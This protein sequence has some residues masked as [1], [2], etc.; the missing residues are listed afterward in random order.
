MKILTTLKHYLLEV[1]VAVVGYVKARLLEKSTWLGISA[2]VTAAAALTPPYSYMVIGIA[3][4]MAILP[5]SK[6]DDQPQ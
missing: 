2:G 5:T 3:V 1:P 4:V 6:N